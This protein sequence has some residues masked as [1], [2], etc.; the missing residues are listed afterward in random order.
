M[1][2][3]SNQLRE[4]GFDFVPYPIVVSIAES[5]ERE[6]RFVHVDIE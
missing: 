6:N 4:D 5:I 3:V 2:S 1:M